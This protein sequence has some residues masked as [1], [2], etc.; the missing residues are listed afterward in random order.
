MHFYSYEISNT[1]S[2]MLILHKVNA[3]LLGY[4]C[5]TGPPAC[6]FHRL[7]YGRG[8]AMAQAVSRR[9]LTAAA[10]VRAQVNPVGFVMD[11][12]ALGQVF[13][14]VLRFSPANIIPP[15]AS[16]FRKW[17]IIALSLTHS[18]PGTN[19]RPLK[20]A[21]VQWDVSLTPKSEYQNKY[22]RRILFWS[23]WVV[24]RPVLWSSVL[25]LLLK[26]RLINDQSINQSSNEGKRIRN[27]ATIRRM[28]L[29]DRLITLS[30]IIYI[31]F[32]FNLTQLFSCVIGSGFPYIMFFRLSSFLSFSVSGGW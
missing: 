24:L 7:K 9:P 8:R 32:T 14:R 21:A 29:P 31:R 27:K 19:N 13:L 2:I 20:A 4:V 25:T 11:K 17:K 12:V 6:I 30:S 22:G 5:S 1:L 26:L 18:H 23:L 28:N 16:H 3:E 15:W 10:R